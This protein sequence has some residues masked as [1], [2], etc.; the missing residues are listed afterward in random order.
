MQNVDDCYDDGDDVHGDG[1]A[2]DAGD[3]GDAVM[4]TMRN[5]QQIEEMRYREN[6]E[7]QKER[8]KRER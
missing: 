1:D 2:G 8:I 3:D 4:M 5:G 7:M 6:E